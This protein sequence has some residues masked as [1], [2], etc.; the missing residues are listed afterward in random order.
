MGIRRVVPDLTT[1]D[2]AA[3]R[4]FYTGLLGFGMDLGWVVTLVSPTNPIA[5]ITWSARTRR[6]PSRR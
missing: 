2:L 4:D 5:Q 1:D 6:A 3:S